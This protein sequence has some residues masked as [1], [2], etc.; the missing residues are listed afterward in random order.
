[1]E[2]ALNRKG[3]RQ[4]WTPERSRTQLLSFT[5]LLDFSLDKYTLLITDLN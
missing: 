2:K 1:M 5:G 3:A 4:D